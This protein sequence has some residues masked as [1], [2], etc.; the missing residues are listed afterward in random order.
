[1]VKIL[2]V[3]IQTVFHQ[4]PI[5]KLVLFGGLFLGLL[6]IFLKVAEL[7]TILT[8][9]E[10]GDWHF[11]LLAVAVETIWMISVAFVYRL[12][13]RSI[14]I[15]E[16]LSKLLQLSTAANFL[17]VVAPTGIS[18]LAVWLARARQ[19]GYSQM[20]VV[21][22]GYLF[23]MLDYFSFLCFLAVG[24]LV[25]FERQELESAELIA[26]I[27]LLAIAI[28]MVLFVYLGIRSP[29][30]LRRIS[31]WAARQSNRFLRPFFHREI[32]PENRAITF[33]NQVS[34]ELHI[35]KQKPRE[36]LMPVVLTLWTKALLVAVLFLMFL[37]FDISFSIG[38][39][40]AAFSMGY[41]FMIVSPTPGGVGV[42]EGTLPLVLS[43]LHIPLGSAAVVALSYRGITFWLPLFFGMLAFRLLSL[44][45]RNEPA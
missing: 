11:I 42:I 8:T 39:L 32:L 26:S 4:L 7:Q 27:F 22:T 30:H 38:T 44:R 14:G 2:T 29:D 45:K 5:R 34:E 3:K 18:G 43:S 20:G 36:L 35:L 33:A 31:G 21:V 37:T 17:N 13:Y 6:F 24:L 1:M 12:I 15:D 23:V 41:L 9:F 40:I 19:R 25:L 10:R 16:S 28:G